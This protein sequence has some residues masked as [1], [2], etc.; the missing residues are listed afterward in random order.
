MTKKKRKKSL[1]RRVVVSILLVG[2]LSWVIGLISIYT[3]GKETIEKSIGANFQA[4]ASQTGKKI[5]LILNHRIYE[6]K[7][8]SSLEL[9]R[10]VVE[11]A[12]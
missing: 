10:S 6:I 9:I 2:I 4:L 7:T 8:L 12:N 5:E 3:F 1:Q 11:D